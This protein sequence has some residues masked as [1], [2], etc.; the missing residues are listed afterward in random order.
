MREIKA[1]V[2]VL[3]QDSSTM[4]DEGVRRMLRETLRAHVGNPTQVTEPCRCEKDKETK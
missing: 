1:L 4:S 2:S 3:I